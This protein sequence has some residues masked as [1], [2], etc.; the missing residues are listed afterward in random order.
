VKLN[1]ELL[2]KEFAAN[3]GDALQ[4]ANR[5]GAKISQRDSSSLCWRN[6][7]RDFLPF[8]LRARCGRANKPR[9]AVCSAADNYTQLRCQFWNRQH[10]TV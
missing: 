5:N 4:K 8:F 6:R 10:R 9:A 1:R 7:E 2:S 3:E